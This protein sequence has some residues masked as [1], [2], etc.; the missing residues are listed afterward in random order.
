MPKRQYTSTR[1]VAA[2]KIAAALLPCP[3][4]RCGRLVT[5]DM[6]WNADHPTARV[7]AEAQ[8]IPEHE[9]DRTVVPS[10]RSCDAKAGA[11]TGNELRAKAKA[12]PRRVPKVKRPQLQ[13]SSEPS[14]TPA[15]APQNPSLINPQEAL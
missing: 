12:E 5:A 2:R 11:K 8:G 1:S 9:Q 14:N 4:Y 15:A 10:H 13:F 7:H 3:C 6:R